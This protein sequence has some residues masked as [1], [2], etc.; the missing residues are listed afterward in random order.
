MITKADP[1]SST[2]AL[3]LPNSPLIFPT[4]HASQLQLFIPNDTE[5]YPLCEHPKPG[6]MMT[7]E[8]LK[9][10]QVEQILDARRRGCGWSFLVRWAGYGAEVDHW[11]PGSELANCEAL[12]RWLQEGGVGLQ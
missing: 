9:E 6:P 7:P 8:G 3:D 2:Y 1:T 5:L 10:Y 4:F 12:N 11:L